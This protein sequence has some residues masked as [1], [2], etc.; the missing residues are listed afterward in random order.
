M[1]YEL[2]KRWSK[3]PKDIWDLPAADFQEMLDHWEIEAYEAGV[4]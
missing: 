1:V 4:N 2:A 3:L